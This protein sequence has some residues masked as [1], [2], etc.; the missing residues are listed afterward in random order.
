MRTLVGTFLLGISLVTTP[1]LAQQHP[2]VPSGYTG[3]VTHSQAPAKAYGRISNGIINSS[4]GRTAKPAADELYGDACETGRA[5]F[6]CPG[7]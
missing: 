1:A 3:T 5:A 2:W 4:E 6:A 7:K